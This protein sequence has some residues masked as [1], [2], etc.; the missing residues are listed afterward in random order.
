MSVVSGDPASCS[1]LGGSLRQ[2]ATRLRASDR[3]VRDAREHVAETSTRPAPLRTR[4]RTDALESAIAAAARE[5]DRVGAALQAHAS[6]LAEA[7][8]DARRIGSRAAQAGLQVSADG[9]VSTALGVSGLADEEANAVQ[10]ATCQRLQ[11]ELDGVGSLVA[12]RRQRLAATLRE[13]QDLL[14]THVGA[15]R[16]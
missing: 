14:A 10:H 15:L 12:R 5:A 3:A 2:L 13:S 9:V 4:R 16:R 7:V 6:D 1:R 11:S 8:A